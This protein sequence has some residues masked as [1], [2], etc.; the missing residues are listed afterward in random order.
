M[1]FDQNLRTFNLD[2]NNTGFPCPKYEDGICGD[3]TKTNPWRYPGVATVLDPC[4]MAGGSLPQPGQ[5]IP[6]GGGDPPPFKEQG[7]L[8]SKLP[9]LKKKTVWI[10]G[11][12]AEVAWGIFANHGGGYSYRL[13]PADKETTEDCF[14]QM[15]LDFVGDTQW[16]QF[17]DG[18]DTTNRTEIKASQTSVGTFPAGSQWRR[19]PVPPCAGGM[20]GTGGGTDPN[21][22]LVPTFD[23][24]MPGVYGFGLG[25]APSRV[26]SA[27]I[28]IVDKVHVPN[29]PSGEYV[30]SW[31][32][33]SEQTSQV[34]QNCGDVTIADDGEASK[35]FVPLD[36]C[37]I[38]FEGGVCEACK[39]CIDSREGDCA[40]C[41]N[42]TV[43]PFPDIPVPVHMTCLGHEDKD[44]GPT[45]SRFQISDV[46]HPWRLAFLVEGVSPGCPRCWKQSAT[47]T[48]EQMVV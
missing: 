42:N 4:G 39:D 7:F 41:Y 19:N 1:G 32:W 23:P 10:A 16:L 12:T 35:P 13:C 9:K 5:P 37:D 28:G 43:K 34:W 26:V 22:C 47:N 27:Q 36:D 33:D 3:W 15:P 18:M 46:F 21:P 25:G 11:S 48:K 38:C 2:G 6:Y 17:G 40:H 45:W 8:G 20:Y 30:L 14:Q 29:V 24:P 44:G 31:R